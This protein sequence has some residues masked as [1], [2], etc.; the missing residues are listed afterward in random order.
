[1]FCEAVCCGWAE[2]TAWF[3]AS[4]S[5][6]FPSEAPIYT[7][8]TPFESLSEKK[9]KT[10]AMPQKLP[11]QAFKSGLNLSSQLKLI[12]WLGLWKLK[13]LSPW[14]EVWHLRPPSQLFWL[15]TD[16]KEIYFSDSL[17]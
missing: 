4:F 16:S 6:I 12:I 14:K 10:C 8:I 5:A 7:K 2:V 15:Y 11:T 9:K 1:M 17:C 13:P 3:E